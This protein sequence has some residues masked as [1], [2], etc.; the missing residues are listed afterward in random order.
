MTGYLVHRLLLAVPVVLGVSVIVFSIVHLVPGD[1]ALAI[2]GEKATERDIQRV[3]KQ[4]GLD[5]PLHEQYFDYV[6][7]VVTKGDFGK[8]YKTKMRVA[9]DLKRCFPA[10][11]ELTLAAMLIATFAGAAFGIVSA[12]RPYSWMDYL[13]MVVALVGVSVPIFFLGMLLL[14]AFAGVFPGSGRLDPTTTLDPVTHFISVD[15]VLRGRWDV[16]AD[17]LAHLALPALAL[18][19]VPMALVA[20]MTRSSML[21]VL[22]SDY[23]RTA[24]AK[25]VPEWR[26]ILRHALRNA[27]VPIVTVLGMEFGHLLA[28]AVLTETVFAWPGIGSYVVDAVNKR[29]FIALQA[30]TLVIACTFITVNLVVDL[31]YAVINPRIRYGRAD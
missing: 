25:G 5:R 16:L 9:E 27:L 3:V 29:D 7:K 30:A 28:G 24:R 6:S 15:A 26:V 19:T 1:P 8:S 21:E 12:V 14:L 17:F 4:Y 18:S 20:R 2:A 10:T 13:S 11:V 22:S 23:V 31:A